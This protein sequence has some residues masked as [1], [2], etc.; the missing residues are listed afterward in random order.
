MGEGGRFAWMKN[1][2]FYMTF[3]QA[4]GEWVQTELT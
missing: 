3:W 2:L 4:A 1:D